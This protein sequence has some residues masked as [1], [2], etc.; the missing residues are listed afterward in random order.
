MKSS[1]TIYGNEI[2]LIE[3]DITR[4]DVDCIVNA[5]NKSLL[6]G[7]GVDGAIHK[8]AGRG[9]YEECLK[10]NGC[11]TGEAKITGGHNLKAKY[12][13]HTVG[14]VYSGNSS[15]SLKLARCYENSLNLALANGV[16]SIAF[17][18]ISTGAYRYPVVE[19]A[20]VAMGALKEWC[21]KNRERGM[22][23]FICCYGITAC[24]CY[25]KYFK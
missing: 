18:S 5:A 25:L 1:I 10:L 19:A 20:E 17:P 11:E 8:A 12:V 15:D 22:K 13:V 6:G 7:G 24:D 16:K 23:I 4:L 9:L 3:G 2:T 14:P 21:R